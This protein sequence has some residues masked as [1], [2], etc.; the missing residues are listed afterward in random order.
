MSNEHAQADDLSPNLP[1]IERRADKAQICAEWRSKEHRIDTEI[2]RMLHERAHRMEEELLA[3]FHA[4]KGHA[5][6]ATFFGSA[7][8]P[9]DNEH[10]QRARSIAAKLCKE[11][12][13]VVTG[14]GP[15]IMEAANR[16]TRE[17]C[18]HATGFNIELPHEQVIN[19]YVTHGVNFHYFF[20]RKVAMFFSADAYVYFPGGYG[21]L[22][23]FFELITLVQTKKLPKVPIILVGSEFWHPIMELC[24][25]LLLE[26]FHTIDAE[27]LDLVHITDN[28]DE[29]V[30]MVKNAP[31]RNEY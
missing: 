5:R 1:R 14:G 24:R 9:E 27:D 7:R 3:G 2:E 16:G 21:T 18:G 11:G 15:G 19:E 13:V 22:D 20:T 10:Y 25:T 17:A 6:S 26:K 8:L 23:E 12:I 30:A 31:L 4:T 28:E 29:V